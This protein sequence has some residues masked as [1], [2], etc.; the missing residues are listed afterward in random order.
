[1]TTVSYC[2]LLKTSGLYPFEL[3]GLADAAGG[4]AFFLRRLDAR[5]G[6]ILALG[7][8]AIGAVVGRPAEHDLG[9]STAVVATGPSAAH[10]VGQAGDGHVQLFELGLDDAAVPPAVLD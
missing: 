9:A 1:M 6:Q 3:V 10:R 2:D 7:Q 4:Q 8:P 5:Q